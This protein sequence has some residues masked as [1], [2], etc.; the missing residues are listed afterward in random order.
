MTGK[1]QVG[2][3]DKETDSETDFPEI[4]KKSLA[5]LEM[6]WYNGLRKSHVGQIR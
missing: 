1:E 4:L 3:M 6:L 5:I 2:I